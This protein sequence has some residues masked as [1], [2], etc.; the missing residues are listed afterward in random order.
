MQIPSAFTFITLL[1]FFPF[2]IYARPKIPLPNDY[3][4]KSKDGHSE[5]FSADGKVV[6]QYA[7]ELN[8]PSTGE[9]RITLKDGSTKKLFNLVGDHDI[10][11]LTTGPRE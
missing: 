5:I 9:T 8:A 2:V 6:Y 3:I 1:V 11:S 4:M 7:L 10:L